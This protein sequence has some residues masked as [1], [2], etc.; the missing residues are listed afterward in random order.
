MTAIPERRKRRTIVGAVTGFVLVG[1]AAALFIVGAI[2]LSNSQEGEAVGVDERPVVALPD[3]PNAMLAVTDDDGEL[4]SVV[5]MT[6]LPE[7]Q[8]GSIVT[9]PVNADGTV[10]FGEQR[11]PLTELFEADDSESIVE[12]LEEMLT[13][14]IER[15]AVVGVDELVEILEPIESLQV[16]LPEDVVDSSQLGSGIV[17]IAGPQTL[18]RLLVAQALA[19]VNDEGASYDHHAVDVELWTQLARTAPIK[20][21]AEPV[22]ID[23]FGRPI[24]PGSVEELVM[25]LWEGDIEVRDIAVTEP[26]ESANPTGADVVLVDRADAV[27][28]FAQISP[29]LVSTPNPAMS[30]RIEARYSDEQ[31]ETSGDL[32]ESSSE[33]VR[34]MTRELL[35]F[36]AN[37]ISIDTAA[38]ADGAPEVTRI[39]VSDERF[40]EDME[41]AGP[42]FFG[43]SVVVVSS[44][45]LDGVDAVV[46]LG[47]GYLDL[48]ELNDEGVVVVR[49]TVETDD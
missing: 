12:P 2:T 33:L 5:I 39:E 47:T 13:I 26:L 38:A 29:A 11:S 42:I 41:L 22:D 10:G 16:V 7:G 28:V 19:A 31:L 36:Q 46:I 34:E 15:S 40:V 9:V 23:E 1:V 49:D 21:P 27:L 6:L 20:V 48:R 44:T 30:F 32:F 14:T 24:P 18:R 3:T 43:E 17:A 25:R 45:V 8:G 37:V 35:F 4:A